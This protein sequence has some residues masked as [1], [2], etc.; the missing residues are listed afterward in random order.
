MIKIFKV[1]NF[2][3]ILFSAKYKFIVPKGKEILIFDGTS[4]DQLRHIVK[5]YDHFILETRLEKLKEFY[6][7][8]KI[9]ISIFKNIKI[10]FFNSYLISLIDQIDPKLILSFIDNSYKFSFFSRIRKKKYKFLAIQNGARYEH[11]ILNLL[12]K[13]K[14]DIEF[15]NF[16]IPYFCCFGEY[17]IYDYK[18]TKQDIGEFNI[19]GS[20][21]LSNFLFNKKNLE[22]ISVKKKNDILL[23]S[24]VY[25]WDKIL[26]KLNFPIE[27]GLINLI[28]FTIKFS[29]KNK[30]K[31]KIAARSKSN[32]FKR[33]KEFYRENL[34]KNDY[35][36][37]LKNIFF[38]SNNFKTYKIMQNSKIVIGTMSTML[39]ENLSLNGKTFACNFTKTDIF[40]F[41]IK[42]LCFSKSSNY[43]DFEKQL[44]EI[45][46]MPIKK[47]HQ[48]LDKKIDYVCNNTSY[49]TISLIKKKCKILIND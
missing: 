47:Y 26:E 30:F 9:I 18:K 13:K 42:G 19:V 44:F 20:L 3:K 22:K 35:K 10:G 2:L 7:T 14:I 21:R 5:D 36:Y 37:L 38:R 49:E 33:E 32:D 48:Q 4:S 24:D 8:K 27:E 17:E 11:K 43:S 46:K 12:R 1:L 45:Y 16:F 40:D 39:R 25:C 28:K 29:R 34:D 23:I 41:P 15:K 31:I 6:I